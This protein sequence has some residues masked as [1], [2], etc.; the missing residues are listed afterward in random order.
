M[1]YN[2]PAS[3][4]VLIAAAFPF[5]L[6]AFFQFAAPRPLFISVADVEHDYVY[7]ARLLR[8]GLPLWSA[9]HPGT[10]VYFL[11]AALM[12]LSGTD[13]L[14]DTDRFLLL[15]RLTA[16]LL[17]TLALALALWWIR[18]AAS[19][20]AALL[21]AALALAWPSHLTY[22]DHFG[23]DAFALAG[24]VL[25]AAALWRYLHTPTRAWR[26]GLAVLCGFM[27]AVKL[28]FVPLV[29]AAGLAVGVETWSE[30]RNRW[31]R[32]AAF[33]GAAAGTFALATA[34]Q[35]PRM[36]HSFFRALRREVFGG[37]PRVLST[38]LEAWWSI[39][40]PAVV[41]S[42]VVLTAAV[43]ILWRR[44]ETLSGVRRR[45]AA[46]FLLAGA[47]ALVFLLVRAR[48]HMAD[49][50]VGLRN[51]G[52]IAVVGSFAALVADAGF[53]R[54]RSVRLRTGIVVLAVVC[55]GYAAV[56]Y[57]EHRARFVR[58][59][60]AR[61]AELGRALERHRPPGVR[62][63]VWDGS[64]GAALGPASFH[65]W[66]NY[67]YGREQ[68]DAAVSAAFPD[69]T[70][71]RFRELRRRLDAERGIDRQAE[72]LARL[73]P[74]AGVAA[75]MLS[76]PGPSP[77]RRLRPL[78]TDAL[79]DERPIYLAAPTEEWTR[80]LLPYTLDDALPLIRE[81]LGAVEVRPVDI[82]GEPWTF[83]LPAAGPNST[84]TAGER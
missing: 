66:G 68:F 61:A 40:A 75:W 57:V 51:L 47:G 1:E 43:W 20:E 76:S 64:P 74:L 65:L 32:L 81:R 63:A 15:A 70:W 7:H 19:T 22:L 69:Y 46:V 52:P 78:F 53:P 17:T 4:L 50:G 44:P 28:S 18:P 30:G 41:V 5:L 56:R 38:A 71:L 79:P 82:A 10:P 2:R 14:P 72:A 84:G 83:I 25:I 73:G 24:S 21:F 67:R 33:V 31:R 36:I 16:A 13:L 49:P 39:S 48:Y 37:E 11:G 35:L 29:G 8:A 6:S 45:G 26:L 55:A 62:L 54:S 42:G 80:E 27:L 58:A 12:A 60:A 23:P 77:S 9:D 3:R 34:P 59:E